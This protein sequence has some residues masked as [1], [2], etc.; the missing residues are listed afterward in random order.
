MVLSKITPRL[1]T[2]LFGY[3]RSSFKLIIMPCVRALAKYGEDRI[4]TSVFFCIEFEKVGLHPNLNF[5][6]T[7]LYWSKAGIII[8]IKWN[9]EL[10][11]ICITVELH[12][13]FSQNVTER[14]KIWG[15][16]PWSPRSSGHF[17]PEFQEIPFNVGLVY[18]SRPAKGCYTSKR[19]LVRLQFHPFVARAKFVIH[20]PLVY[21]NGLVLRSREAIISA[22]DDIVHLCFIGLGDLCF[23]IFICY[24]N[25]VFFPQNPYNRHPIARPW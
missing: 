25:E 17:D 9:I 3:M 11:I 18:W 23:K 10:C 22:S 13:K 12:T 2:A 16:W 21:I 4:I 24:H 1:R 20:L 7:F 5:R 14:K 15:H 8:L 6:Y 19:A